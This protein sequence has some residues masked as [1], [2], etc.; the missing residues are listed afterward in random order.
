MKKAEEH[1]ITFGV[2]TITLITMAIVLVLALVKIN[3]SNRIYYESR[4][5]HLLER[6][7]A[8][9]KEERTLLQMRVEKLQYKSQIADTIFSLDET[10]PRDGNA[11]DRFHQKE[12]AP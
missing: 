10:M 12:P 8:A 3:L 5:I 6:E 9:L 1:G 7:V 2:L 4:Q 11:P